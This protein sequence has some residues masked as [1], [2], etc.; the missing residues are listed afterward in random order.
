M[1][2][3]TAAR[4]RVLLTGVLALLSMIGFMIWNVQSDW[5]FI[6]EYRGSRLLAMLLVAVAMG[7]ST[8][9][10]QTLTHSRILTPS[11]M[12]FDV[13]YVLVHALGVAFWAR[14]GLDSMPSV[15]FILDVL[16]MAGIA[17]VLF[18]LLF[19]DSVRGLHLLILLG[20][21]RAAV[22]RIDRAGAAGAR[23]N[24]IFHPVRA[25]IASFSRINLP[26]YGS[27]WC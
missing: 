13:L 1:G 20:M 16:L 6:V 9:V 24:R 10:F 5:A 2:L 8:L 18:R 15:I 22:S 3:T 21:R 27:A 4:W 19:G 25:Q 11:L 12:G 26:C 14:L 7:V 23:P 17:L